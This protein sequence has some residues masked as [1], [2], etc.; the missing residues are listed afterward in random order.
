MPHLH[1]YPANKR[2]Q[3]QIQNGPYLHIPPISKQP[4]SKTKSKKKGLLKFAKQMIAGAERC[5]KKA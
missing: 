1:R 4:K 3:K 5:L 2:P